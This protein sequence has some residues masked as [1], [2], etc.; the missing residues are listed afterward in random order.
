MSGL[1]ILG[2]LAGCTSPNESKKEIKDLPYVT[3]PNYSWKNYETTKYGLRFKYPFSWGKIQAYEPRKDWLSV[4]FYVEEGDSP[5]GLGDIYI[6]KRSL[7]EDIWHGL[8]W[9][10]KGFEGFEVESFENVTINGALA[11]KV[12][13]RISDAKIVII[14]AENEGRFY[15]FS[16]GLPS[17][18]LYQWDKWVKL[19]NKVLDSFEFI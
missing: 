8:E 9:Y 19:V 2:L 3:W 4:S 18:N 17:D 14:T 6:S 12:I 10:K 1:I 15:T 5:T 7:Q 11:V 13:Y 16:F